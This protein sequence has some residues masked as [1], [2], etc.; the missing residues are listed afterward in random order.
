MAYFLFVG[1]LAITKGVLDLWILDRYL[2]VS[3]SR[4]PFRFGSFSYHCGHLEPQAP[5][6]TPVGPAD[7]SGSRRARFRCCGNMIKRLKLLRRTPENFD[8]TARLWR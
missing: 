1:L 5:R 4:L 2:L 8:E 6:S 3:P 7:L